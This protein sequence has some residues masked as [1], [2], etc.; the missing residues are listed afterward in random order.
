MFIVMHPFRVSFEFKSGGAVIF[1]LIML[2]MMWNS[3]M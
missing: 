3:G 1:S 2:R